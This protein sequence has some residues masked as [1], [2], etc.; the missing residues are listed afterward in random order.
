MALALERYIQVSISSD[1]MKATLSF[2]PVNDDEL[3]ITEQNLEAFLKQQGVT[4]GIQYDVLSRI[5]RDP[6]AFYTE[7]TVVAL[8]CPAEDGKDGYI[9][10]LAPNKDA[11]EV[12]S[13]DPSKVV[14]LKEVTKLNNVSKGQPLAKKVPATEGKNGISVTG[15][16]VKSKKG[17]EARFKIGKNVVQSPDQM[18]LYAAIDGLFTYTEN[19]VMNVFPVYEVNG[20]VDYSVGNIQFVGNVIIRGNVLT[21]FKVSAAGDIRVVGGIEGAQLEAGGSIDVTAGILGHNKGHVKAGKRI[22]SS[23]IQDAYVEAAEEVVVSQSIMHSHVKAGKRVICSGSKG[24]IVGGTIQAGEYVEA[25]TIGNTMST[26]TTLEVGVLP[27]LRN[28]LSTLRK[29]TN[30]H[31]ENLDKTEKALK[32]LDQ[33]ASSGQISQDK[34]AMRVKLTNTKKQLLEEIEQY[35]ERMLSIEKMLENSVDAYIDVLSTIY[36]GTKVVL[37]RQVRYIKDEMKYVRFHLKEGEIFARGRA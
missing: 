12:S 3:V 19:E 29:K 1:K 25:R 24:L 26:S 35:K 37:G 5:A 6:M 10:L 31:Y 17:L 4:F 16:E 36:G 2:R 15:E 33:L 27:E 11:D 20:D 13:D 34:L 7:K 22:I 9:E 28:E 18:T 14:D 32:I 8:G 23:F 21:G 30:E